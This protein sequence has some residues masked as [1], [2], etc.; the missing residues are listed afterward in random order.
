MSVC[1]VVVGESTKHFKIEISSVV[2]VK[3]KCEC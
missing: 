3:L 2:S 1:N